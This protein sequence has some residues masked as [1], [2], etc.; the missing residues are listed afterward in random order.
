MLPD[1]AV[2]MLCLRRPRALVRAHQPRLQLVRL[3]SH[4][5][6]TGRQQVLLI[7]LFSPIGCG[8][9]AEES[10]VWLR[11]L[12]DKCGIV[13][14]T[15]GDGGNAEGLSGLGNDVNGHSAHAPLTCPARLD[16]YYLRVSGVLYPKL[17]QSRLHLSL[18]PSPP[19]SP[20]LACLGC[21]TLRSKSQLGGI[22]VARRPADS[23]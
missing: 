16:V 18:I 14:I 23:A 4:H 15:I 17:R 21:L 6:C 19:G 5:A 8:P 12:N 7:A 2:G 9:D 20:G 1:P 13:H 3:P 22:A 11:S 10:W